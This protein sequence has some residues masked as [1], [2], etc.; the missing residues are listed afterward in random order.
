ML[1]MLTMITELPQSV[2]ISWIVTGA[3]AAANDTVVE[4]YMKQ[5]MP[6]AICHLHVEWHFALT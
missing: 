6:S 1:T 2:H 3:S 5:A 4:A